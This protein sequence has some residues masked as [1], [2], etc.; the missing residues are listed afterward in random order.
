MIAGG[1]CR[2]AHRSQAAITTWGRICCFRRDTVPVRIFRAIRRSRM[3]APGSS[4]S[5]PRPPFRT[6][7]LQLTAQQRLARGTAFQFNYTWSKC[8]TNNRNTMAMATRSKPDHG[9]RLP[10]IYLQRGARLGYAIPTRAE[11]GYLTTCPSG[12]PDVRQGSGKVVNAILGDWL[13]H[14]REPPAASRSP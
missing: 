11:F 8:L 13:R 12:R 1:L 9:R 3:P 7:T 4:G 6:T 2:A 10:V 14:H 5:I